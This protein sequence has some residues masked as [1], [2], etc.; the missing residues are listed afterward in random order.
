MSDN[1]N[2]KNSVELLGH[3]GG[4]LTHSLSAWTSTSRDLDDEKRARIGKLLKALASDRHTSPFE[5]SALHFLV[6]ADIAT[7]IH[8]IKHRIGVSVNAESAR[9]KEYVEDKAYVP[10][11]WPEHLAIKLQNWN[12]EA[13]RKYHEVIEELEP[14]LGR[15]RAKESAR[16][17]LPYSTQLTQDILFNWNSFAHFYDLRAE[18]DDNGDPIAQKEV[19]DIAEQ[20]LQL[21]QDT[22]DF[23]LTIAAFYGDEK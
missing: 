14:V 22:N 9:Y 6:T 10:D 7:H 17:F 11:D 12:D 1:Y 16:Y 13:F 20:M 15:K 8:I 19:N 18:K 21:I 4:D 5:K 2:R 3:Y 23:N